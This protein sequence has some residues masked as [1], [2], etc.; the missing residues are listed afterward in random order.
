[1][2]NR[3]PILSDL[4][5]IHAHAAADD[6][7][8]VFLSAA[9]PIE[10]PTDPA[11]PIP[12]EFVWMPA[13]EHEISAVNAAG[14]A[15]KGKILCDE[16][17]FRAVAAKFDEITAAGGRVPLD[18]NHEDGEATAWIE[19]FRWDAAR[20]ILCRVSW[21]SLG[22]QLL[23]GRVF[24][25]FSPSFSRNKTTA[26]VASFPSGGH[27]AGGL[28]NAPAFGAAMP[29]LIAARLSGADLN[30]ASG[31]SPVTNKN[32][33]MKEII[34]Q[35]LAALAVQVPAD[36]NEEQLTQL[37]AANK[38]KLTTAC[39]TNAELRAKALQLE[40]LQAKHATENTELI[41]LRAKD[42]TRREADA[43]KAVDA[44]VARGAIPAKDEAIQAKWRGMIEA[45][46][47]HADLLAAMPGNPA[48]QRVTSP[49]GV[50]VTAQDNLLPVLQQLQAKSTAEVDL[51]A[52]IYQRDI[53]PLFAKNLQFNQEL[54]HILAANSLGALAGELVTQ[55]TF[56]LLKLQFPW[57][58]QISTDFS[59]E[60]GSF[61]QVVK[62]RLK[63]LP[64]KVVYVPGTGYVRS[65]A[66]ATDAPITISNHEGVEI[67]FNV[68]ELS[69]TNRDLFGEQIEGAHYVIGKGLV[70]SLLAVITAAN[71]ANATTQA[72][73]TLTPANSLD[74]MDAALGTRGVNGPR[75]GLL[76]S[77]VF[78]KLGN[79]TS[80]VTL[81]QFQM[82]EI[83]T[84]AVLP[85]IKNIQPHEV[86]NLPTTGDLTGFAGT[87]NALAIATRLPNDYTQGVPG[88]ASNGTV[89]VVK[90]LD[91]G[92]SAQLVRYVDHKLAESAWRL[93]LMWGVAKGDPAAGQ[94]LISA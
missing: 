2:P 81:A 90:N 48:L 28:V 1:M 58:F 87:A 23:R 38:D 18:K 89:Q 15:W 8:V 35:I 25:S 6:D 66:G 67:A 64:T 79:D 68:N 5:T 30:P 37:L 12:T 10:V 24:R 82:K 73:A 36:A 43:K 40:T 29:A 57:L 16:V 51:R 71:F 85:P 77:A 74:L 7:S 60:G 32:S 88:V 26:R 45:N 56:S 54:S 21:T 59:A 39:S 52:S 83:I 33:T 91:T 86:F 62:A 41:E 4:L 44:A 47:D 3:L 70:D 13:G 94:R 63:T 93:A 92:V 17:G 55:R 34:T 75:I 78:R 42:K 20:G 14:G 69:S 76:S 19:G 50:V 11:Q 65:D 46:P 22:E 9:S 84:Q 80:I 31:G 27:A 49:A 61:G 72:T 53:S